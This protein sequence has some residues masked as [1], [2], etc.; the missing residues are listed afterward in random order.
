LKASKIPRRPVEYIWKEHFPY[1]MMGI[2]AGAPGKGK[3]TFALKVAAD[4]SHEEPVIVSSYEEPTSESIIPKLEAAGADMDNVDIQKYRFPGGIKKLARYVESEGARLLIMDTASDHSGASIYHVRDIRTTFEPLVELCDET[5]LSVLMVSHTVK[6]IDIKADPL[7]AIGGSQGGLAAMVRVAYLF[8]Y[9]PSD[10]DERCL[11]QLKCNIDFDR[12]SLRLGM[13][14]HEF[15]DGMTAPF[16]TDLGTT[17][18]SALDVFQA[19][20]KPD[21]AKL[22]NTAEWLVENLFANGGVLPEKEIIEKGREQGYN[23]RM[24]RRVSDHLE[25]EKLEGNWKLP[26]VPLEANVEEGDERG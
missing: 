22:E 7:N 3:S 16:L 17:R 8:G 15:D 2:V 6:K 25:L 24:I 1:G 18:A 11:V 10:V 21:P 26:P 14:V 20:P 4:V 19:Q 5:D 12:P 9:S 13:D 23:S